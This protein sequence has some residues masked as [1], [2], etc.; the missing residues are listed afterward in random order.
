MKF[1]NNYKFVGQL[2]NN[3]L[4]QIS[5]PK[6]LTEFVASSNYMLKLKFSN[7]Y[8]I[9][10]KIKDNLFKSSKTLFITKL[11]KSFVMNG[12]NFL[13]LKNIRFKKKLNKY[14]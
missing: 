4:T 2:L 5:F 13:N 8:K 10:L 14:T 3:H 12:L 9:H 7:Q 1:K 11:F 6:N